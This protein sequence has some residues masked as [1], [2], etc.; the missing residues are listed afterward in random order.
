MQSCSAV[1]TKSYA[2]RIKGPFNIDLDITLAL[3]TVIEGYIF[4]KTVGIHKNGVV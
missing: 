2:M 4:P 3:L 1:V